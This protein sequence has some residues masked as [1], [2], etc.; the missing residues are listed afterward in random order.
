MN[1]ERGMRPTASRIR[2]YS[3]LSNFE[4]LQQSAP[5]LPDS[6]LVR[7]IRMATEEDTWATNIKKEL[8]E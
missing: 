7:D 8:Q 6:Y 5:S 2:L 1:F 3:T 4:S